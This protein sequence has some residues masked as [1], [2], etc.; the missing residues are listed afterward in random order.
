MN[1]ILLSDSQSSIL[2]RDTLNAMYKEVY[3]AHK[4]ALGV[5]RSAK[6]NRIRLEARLAEIEAQRVKAN[7]R[8]CKGDSG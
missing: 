5:E 6:Q 8:D 4:N 1:T 7:E 2:N 3:E